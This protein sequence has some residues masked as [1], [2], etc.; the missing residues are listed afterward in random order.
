[1]TEMP[2]AELGPLAPD[3][4][5]VGE[6]RFI[7]G[8]FTQAMYLR[9]QPSQALEDRLGYNRGTLAKGW[10]LVFA[11]DKP[12][13]SNFE[14]GGYTYFSGGRIGPPSLGDTR[15]TVETSLASQLGKNLDGQR[16]SHV[17]NFL[18]IQGHLRLAKV[19]SVTKPTEFPM[20]TGIYQCNI[21][22]P[23]R[24]RVAA[25]VEPGQIYTGMYE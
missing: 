19:I 8:N 3:Q 25:F 18:R 24:C 17:T 6:T 13:P 14:F 21:R 2:I 12:D 23:I 20:G 10:W 4:R 11:I 7:R 15:T 1:M 22:D 5:S 16:R 9:S